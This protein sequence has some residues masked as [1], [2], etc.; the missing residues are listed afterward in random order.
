M[1]VN[2]IVGI[3]HKTYFGYQQ[4]LEWCQNVADNLRSNQKVHENIELFTFPAMPAIADGMAIFRTAVW[5]L[6]RKMSVL[7]LLERGQARPVL[8]C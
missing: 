7:S 6:G 4:T 8:P 1:S 5:R 2:V 3:S